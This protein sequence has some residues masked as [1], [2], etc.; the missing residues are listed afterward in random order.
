VPG[1]RQPVTSGGDIRCYRSR[2][3]TTEIGENDLRQAQ[4]V[5]GHMLELLKTHA[6]DKQVEKAQYTSQNTCS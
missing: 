3:N 1:Q 4:V 6:S 5:L 2:P